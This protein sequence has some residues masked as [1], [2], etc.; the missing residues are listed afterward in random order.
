MEEDYRD[1]SGEQSELEDDDEDEI[2][3]T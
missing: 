3:V 1:E 2:N